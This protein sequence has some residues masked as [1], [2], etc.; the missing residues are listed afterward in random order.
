MTVSDDHKQCLYYKHVIKCAPVVAQPE[1]ELLWCHF[2]I[3]WGQ[4]LIFSSHWFFNET[5]T[6]ASSSML[7]RLD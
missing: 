1:V 2:M 7:I 4:S 3:W 6:L 5:D